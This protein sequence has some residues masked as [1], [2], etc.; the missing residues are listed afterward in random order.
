M[1]LHSFWA[2][3]K[4]HTCSRPVWIMFWFH[5]VM[6]RYCIT[7]FCLSQVMVNLFFSIFDLF[8]FIYKEKKNNICTLQ[9]T[10]KHNKQILVIWFTVWKYVSINTGTSSK[11]TF[12]C[13]HKT[14]QSLKSLIWVWQWKKDA[15]FINLKIYFYVHV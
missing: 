6:S 11:I 5:H 4:Q 12:S 7:F 13:A 3:Y 1:M 9:T 14:L 8:S 15:N 10:Y 2:D